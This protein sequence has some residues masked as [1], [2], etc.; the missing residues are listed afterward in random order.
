M[1][2]L[3]YWELFWQTGSPE[4]YLL[5]SRQQK[6]EENHVSDC[7]GNRPSGDTIQ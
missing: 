1:N 5:Y 4:A 2:K 6:K 3:N 7:P